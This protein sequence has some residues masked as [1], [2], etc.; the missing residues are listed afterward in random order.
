[1]RE[2]QTKGEGLAGGW[3]ALASDGASTAGRRGGGSRYGPSGA[4]EMSSFSVRAGVICGGGEAACGRQPIGHAT[5]AII[6]LYF[7]GRHAAA[8]AISCGP[9]I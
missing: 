6:G 5:A 4:S 3:H 2:R 8:G 1:M 7:S 9:D